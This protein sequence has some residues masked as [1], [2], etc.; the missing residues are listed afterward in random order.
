MMITLAGFG[1]TKNEGRVMKA[2]EFNWVTVLG[3]HAETPSEN[4]NVLI[5]VK[6]KENLTITAYTYI[7]KYIY[8]YI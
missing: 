4:C 6:V 2:N 3:Q 7:N 1:Y 8:I 5:T